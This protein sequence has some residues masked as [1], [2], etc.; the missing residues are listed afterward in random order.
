MRLPQRPNLEKAI[1]GF[2][3]RDTLAPNVLEEA[4]LMLQGRGAVLATAREVCRVLRKAEIDAA[5]IGGVAVALHGHIRTTVDVD[6]YVPGPLEA[7]RQA[8]T[9]AGFTFNAAVREFVRKNV[10]V[11]LVTPA[12]TR[13]SPKEYLEI[14]KI[15]T[16]GLADLI[17]M[18]LQSGSRDLLRAQDLADVI[19]LIRRHQLPPTFAAKIPKPLRPE[20]RRLARAIAKA[21]S[22]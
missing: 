22:A 21:E 6:V 20:F 13:Y 16:V 19:G 4:V 3:S 17:A 11:H 14:A 8:L 15:R 7:V 2:G 5:V 18:K 9:A 10:P 1:P 12:Q